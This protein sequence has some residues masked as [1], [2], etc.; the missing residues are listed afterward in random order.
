M[1]GVNYKNASDFL[2]IDN[3]IGVG[4]SNA[5]VNKNLVEKNEWNLIESN[6]ISFEEVLKMYKD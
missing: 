4:V 5:L 1:G 2:K 6:I 3:V